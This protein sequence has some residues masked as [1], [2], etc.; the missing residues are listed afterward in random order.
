MLTRRTTLLWSVASVY[1]YNMSLARAQQVDTRRTYSEEAEMDT[2]MLQWMNAPQASTSPLHLG[3]FADR[4]Y[5]LLDSINWQP[6]PGQ[7][8]SPL[9]VPRGFVTDFA[10]IPRV[11]WSLLP[12]DGQYT[13]AAIIHD[14][15][16]W[17]QN[18]SKAQADR[19]LGYV[20]EE[21][22]VDAASALAIS[23]GVQVGGGSAWA[24]NAR[25]KNGGEKR[26]LRKFPSRPTETWVTWRQ[27]PENF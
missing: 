15:L 12:P 24:E 22:K 6:D 23:R 20:M 5:W 4:R 19:I 26:V 13:Y 7:T 25:L 3:R 8:G 27:N 18:V 21:F 1:A 16:Y 17:E 2:W 11:F 14:Y 10:S 9:T